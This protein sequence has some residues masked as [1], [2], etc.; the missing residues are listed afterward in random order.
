MIIFN[1]STRMSQTTSW[2]DYFELNTG[3]LGRKY[4][5]IDT[6]VVELPDNLPQPPSDYGV[7]FSGCHHLVNIDVLANWDT[8]NMT[9]TSGMFNHCRSLADISPLR[10]WNLSNVTDMSCMFNCCYELA[11][12]SAIKMWDISNVKRMRFIFNGC[13]K[14]P[15]FARLEVYDQ[16]TFNCFVERYLWSLPTKCP[17]Y[18][19]QSDENIEPLL[20]PEIE[21]EEDYYEPWDETTM[22]PHPFPE[23]KTV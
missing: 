8:S 3:G 13:R 4:R 14:L 9:S 2:E 19:N 21:E 23:M 12:V 1:L 10:Y 22:G 15:N 5:Y 18:Y 11:D 16:Q 20:S 17:A 6:S 7:M